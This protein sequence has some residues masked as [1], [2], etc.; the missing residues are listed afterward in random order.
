MAIESVFELVENRLVS[1]KDVLKKVN[2]SLIETT[3]EEVKAIYGFEEKK[4]NELSTLEKS[5]IADL[6]SSAVLKYSLDRYKEDAKAKVGPDSLVH[7]AQDKLKY[8]KD[9]IKLF[10]EDA[11]LK[12]GKL[13]LDLVSTPALVLKIGAAVETDE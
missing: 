13:G 3:I 2:S 1:T 4:D 8:L 6:A 12:A 11:K 10:E 9:Q 7:E 5:Y